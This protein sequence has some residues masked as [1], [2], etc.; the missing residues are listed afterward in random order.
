MTLGFRK[1]KNR[2]NALKTPLFQRVGISA[3]FFIILMSFIQCANMQRPT[4][5]P[6]DSIPPQLLEVTPA[7][8]S[9]NFK[10]TE[11]V[12]TF[13]EF[14]KTVNPGKEFSISPDVPTQPIYKVRKK[15]LIIEL[16]DSLAENTTYTI[17]F[18]KG[19]VDYNEG[20]PFINYN[21]V[22]ATGDVLDSLSISGKVKNGYSKDFDL[23]K[24]KEVIAILIPTSQDTIFGKKKASYYTN[25]DSSGNFQF[26]NL[27]EDSYRVY[28]LKDIN[29]DK[30]YN[31]NDEWIGFQ[32]DSIQLQ[33]NVSGI[34]LEYT[35][36]KPLVFRNLEKKIDTDGSLLLTFNRPLEDPDFRIL[37][38]VDMDETKLVKVVPT[39][40]S[41]RMYFE[42]L[43][44]DSL[45]IEVSEYQEVVDTISLR[46]ARNVK[47][48]QTIVPRLNI[49]NQVDRIKHIELSSSY[50]ISSI[51][52]AKI[53]I[54][55]DSVSRRNFQ[56]QKDTINSEMYHIRFNWKPEID[57]ELVVEEGAIQGP[58]GETNEEFKAQFTLNQ[59]E[60][61]GDIILKFTG[62]EKEKNYIVELIDESKEKTFD[63]RSLP[64][65]HELPF[66]KYPGG[67]YSIRLIEDENGNGKWDGGDVYEL[68]QAEPIW[69]LNRTFT[70]RANWEQNETIDVN[71]D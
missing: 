46:K 47:V 32:Q 18:G 36:G 21:F 12:L 57:Y 63:V 71:F 3:L 13:D 28:A 55:E 29:G 19:L 14:I 59:T 37:D 22:F 31:G 9:L 6:K 60:N 35:K 15:N 26:N 58:F 44:F 70:I 38:P 48:D 27:R 53:L 68:R 34:E 20:N 11:I 17:N 39:A 50:P 7:N 64:D 65:N 61:Y 51:D 23:E 40:D 52:N 54:M 49:S 69:Y 5:G 33:A 16:P 56:L 45:K 43:E 66:I 1:S 62:L 67:K 25:V 10:E 2:S 8:L 24:D 4:G 41:A 30:I 42:H